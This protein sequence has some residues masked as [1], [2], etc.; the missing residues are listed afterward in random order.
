MKDHPA[1]WQVK[2]AVRC[3]EWHPKSRPYIVDA[4]G[5]EVVAMPQFVD[6]PGNY[7]AR[8]EELAFAIVK[9]MNF[10]QARK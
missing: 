3:E 7:D 9:A 4:N 10:W 2:Y 8:A 5:I 6:H 1:P